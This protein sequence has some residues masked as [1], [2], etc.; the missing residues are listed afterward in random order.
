MDIVKYVQ[1]NRH[2]FKDYEWLKQF[3]PDAQGCRF[4]PMTYPGMSAKY[5]MEE[6]LDGIAGDRWMKE[7]SKTGI[8]KKITLEHFRR[9]LS[10]E[11]YNDLL[12]YIAWNCFDVG[13]ARAVSEGL[14]ELI[15]R[16]QYECV[17][18]ARHFI[19]GPE[20]AKFIILKV[21][22]LK[23]MRRVYQ[24]RKEL[25]SKLE[26]LGHTWGTG[27]INLAGATLL[28]LLGHI[29]P[30]DP[31][32]VEKKKW[33]ILPW[34]V[35]SYAL[36]GGDGYV[37][38]SQNRYHADK[39]PSVVDFVL[40]HLEPLDD[41][42]SRLWKQLTGA[43]SLFG[44]LIHYD[45][46]AGFG[47]VGPF[48]VEDGKPMIIRNIY[49]NE[50][51]YAWNTVSER[52]GLPFSIVTAFVINPEKVGLKEVR[53]NDI[54]TT[55]TEPADV[56]EGI[57]QAC[58]FLRWEPECLEPLPLSKL[59]KVA[60]DEIPDLVAKLKEGTIE[61]Y[62][63]TAKLTRR[64]KIHNGYLVY[65]FDP[66]WGSLLRGL[67]LLDYVIE[68]L[69]YWEMPPISSEVY[70]Q[71]KGRVALEVF[72]AS[73]VMGSEWRDIPSRIPLVPTLL[74]WSPPSRYRDY[75]KKARELGWE[76]DLSGTMPVPD[77]LKEH[78]DED[79]I[80]KDI[81]EF[82]VPDNWMEEA[83]VSKSKKR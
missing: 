21:G 83:D 35:R 37:M 31:L 26:H 23:F 65:C 53:T 39:D 60:W 63:E 58:L 71:V 72:P 80:L 30:E 45:C 29:E 59:Q 15:P 25:G 42:K 50:P 34:A 8:T 32:I 2:K 12:N 52:R 75:L 27:A 78:M 7:H 11:E 6:V 62:T 5:G 18:I 9:G 54:G 43:A 24:S 20:F 44:F 17:N 77:E 41:K 56:S 73:W 36:R 19:R 68:K 64:A 48:I 1:E 47:D 74:N 70:Y 67:G 13:A 57:E 46:R 76:S 69:D 10:I 55:F 22:W 79:C 38:T 81:P 14:S 66:H 61:W 33:A 16:Q 40:S 28:E 82:D 3:E 51:L 49:I 4:A